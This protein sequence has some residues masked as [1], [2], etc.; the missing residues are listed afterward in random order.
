MRCERCGL[1]S[2]DPAIFRSIH[3]AFTVSRKTLCAPCQRKT[4]EQIT[5][6]VFVIVLA[7]TA[8]LAL[9]PFRRDAP[10]LVLIL[11][12]YPL[13][14][15][16]MVAHEI[17]HTLGAW[18]ARFRVF[19]VTIGRGKE[20]MRFNALG[21]PVSLRVAPVSGMV[22]CGTPSQRHW[23]LRQMGVVLC[24]PLVNVLL[25]GAA[26]AMIALAP[27]AAPR[28]G[29]SFADAP[30]WFERFL[31][32][33]V[34]A[35]VNLLAI[36][37]NLIP[38]TV[39]TE[40]GPFAS[41]GRQLWCLIRGKIPTEQQRTAAY[42]H[43]AGFAALTAGRY[44]EALRYFQEGGSRVPDEPRFAE[45]VGCAQLFLRRYRDAAQ[46]LNSLLDVI[47]APN[48][49]RPRVL[50]NLAIAELMADSPDLLERADVHSADAMTAAPGMAWV[51]GTRG[52]IL[53]TRGDVEEG[54][55][56]LTE[57]MKGAPNKAIRAHLAA[58][59]ALAEHRRGNSAAAEKWL[60]KAE[61]W[62]RND[63]AIA[64]VRRTM[65]QPQASTEGAAVLL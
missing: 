8:V 58:F 62:D 50:N 28:S 17:G 59:L 7:E 41:D 23:R 47:P 32:W 49:A 30:L 11:M 43:G 16:S 19:A 20:L 48:P 2:D 33:H 57:S 34:L 61:R 18:A 40:F 21:V 13:Q 12:F 44:D 25:L 64:L 36:V 5:V 38:R 54:V 6:W 24:G 37:G 29:Y 51:K 42:Y 3:K 9:P 46:T 63:D 4:E 15:A 56:L 52:A 31:I 1:E 22:A 65:L 45:G 26:V 39:Q 10:W 55:R 14:I 53:V 60:R 35:I 27:P